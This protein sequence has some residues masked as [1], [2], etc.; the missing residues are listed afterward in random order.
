M[1]D[2]DKVETTSG[3]FQG[4]AAEV[5][6][7][8]ENYSQLHSIYVGSFERLAK[9]LDGLPAQYNNKVANAKK[10]FENV[11]GSVDEKQLEISNQLYSQGLVLLVGAAESI[12]KE[13]FRTLLIRNIRKVSIKRNVAL[14][15]N[16]VLKA[17]TNE[18]L[19]KLILEVLEGEGNPAEKLNFQNMK[20]LQGIMKG[21]L[22]IELGD[23]L[24][25]EL[26]EYWQ[27]RHIVIHNAS[28]IDQQF[29][30][31][32][33]K[34]KIPTERYIIGSKITVAKADYDKCF[35]LLVLLF[36]TLDSEIDKLKLTYTQKNK[37]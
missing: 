14:P 24:M 11:R 28:I 8:I 13:A 6:S 31:N 30:D 17:E 5:E 33:N 27:I 34:A 26:H 19:A 15:A 32:L 35:A 22:S 4:S 3:Q 21:Y 7:I 1:T 25:A 12:T 20:Q 36:E 9:E 18:Q 10:I 2:P 23:E 37:A 29:I 16:K